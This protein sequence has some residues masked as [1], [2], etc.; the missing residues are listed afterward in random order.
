M[1]QCWRIDDERQTLVLASL[2]KRVPQVVYWGPPLPKGEDLAV[3]SAAY[4]IDVTGGMLDEHADLSLCPEASRSFPGQPGLILRDTDGTPLLP[5][6]KLLT[7]ENG[8][9]EIRTRWSGVAT[10]TID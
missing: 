4:A 1:K 2:G 10:R 9:T 5:Q 7:V 3:I 8:R 6:F